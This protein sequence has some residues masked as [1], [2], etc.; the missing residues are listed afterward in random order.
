MKAALSVLRGRGIR[1]EGSVLVAAAVK[2]NIAQQ[3]RQQ[4]Q[5]SHKTIKLVN[6]G[7]KATS[8]AAGMHHLS[9]TVER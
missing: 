6:D 2:K 5:T 4:Q 3:Q 7:S 8:A 1:G 9:E